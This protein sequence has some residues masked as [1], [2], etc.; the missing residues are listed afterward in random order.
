M[1]R[2]KRFVTAR[3]Y[4]IVVS[5]SD[6]GSRFLWGYLRLVVSDVHGIPREAPIPPGG[7]VGAFGDWSQHSSGSVAFGRLV[8]EVA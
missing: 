5:A 8:F 3:H 2:V 1:V 7:R 6:H 4:P